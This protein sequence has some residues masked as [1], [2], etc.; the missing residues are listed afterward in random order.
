MFLF[1]M[2]YLSAL[3]APPFL[4]GLTWWRWLHT[5]RFQPPKWRTIAFFSGLF[6]GTCNLALW[7]ICVVWL[8]FHSNPS[9]W[10]FRDTLIDVGIYLL[11]YSIVAAIAG[12]GRYRLLLGISGVLAILPWILMGDL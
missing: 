1:N 4:L 9:S 10:R 3:G 8:K 7:W 12:K 2:M 5:P 11:L 6:A